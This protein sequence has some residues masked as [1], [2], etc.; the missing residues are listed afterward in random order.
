MNKYCTSSP[1]AQIDYVA[2]HTDI[3]ELLESARS[4]AARSVNALMTASYWEIG[5]RIVEFEQ[6]GQTRAEYGD[7]LLV[8][9]ATDLSARFGSGF[10]RRN[11]QQMRLFYLAWPPAPSVT[12][13]VRSLEEAELEY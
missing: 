9:L 4:T 7:A 5:R 1:P 12:K 8:R 2:V 6:R 3:V 11:L 10:S 13:D